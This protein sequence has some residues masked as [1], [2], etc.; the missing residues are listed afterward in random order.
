MCG[1]DYNCI[2]MYTYM[3][4]HICVYTCV[5]IG[6]LYIV[7]KEWNN[8]HDNEIKLGQESFSYEKCGSYTTY[9]KSSRKNPAKILKYPWR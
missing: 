9:L 4:I 1:R 5:Y 2:Y 7:I 6:K 3:C 8:T